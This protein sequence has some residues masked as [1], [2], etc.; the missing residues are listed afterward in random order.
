M[1]EDIS[2]GIMLN[3]L[4]RIAPVINRKTIFQR[5]IARE[6]VS[7]EG[8]MRKEYLKIPYL[9]CVFSYFEREDTILDKRII[10]VGD[11]VNQAMKVAVCMMNY[12]QKEESE[13][14]WYEQQ[15]DCKKWELKIINLTREIK[16]EEGLV[17]PWV[18][19]LE[20]RN[21][22]MVFYY[23]VNDGTTLKHKVDLIKG[24]KNLTDFIY[25]EK[26]DME[27]PWLLELMKDRESEIV[28]IEKVEEEY[29]RKILEQLLEGEPYYL[30]EKMNSDYLIKIWKKKSGNIFTEEDIAWALDR[31][32]RNKKRQENQFCLG[33]EDFS[34]EP[35]DIENPLVL[36]NH[37][38]G[39]KGVKQVALEYAALCKEKCRNPKLQDVSKHMIFVGN[40]GT[41]KTFCA[42]HMA[43]IAGTYGEA[44]GNYVAVTRK[45]LVGKYVGHTAPKVESL[46]RQTRGGI[47]FVDEAG[48]F[49]HDND[50]KGFAK[51]AIKEFVRFMDLYQDTTVI[52]SLYPMEVEEWLKQ[53]AGLSSRIGRVVEFEDYSMTEL[54]EITELM[55]KERGYYIAEDAKG[56]ALSYL[57]CLNK[58]KKENFGNAREA[59]KL[60]ESA[61]ISR[62]IRSFEAEA[63]D[64]SLLQKADF[65]ESLNRLK[66]AEIKKQRMGF[67]V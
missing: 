11:N 48:W 30:A 40:P 61:I 65:E 33:Y 8:S 13:E 29:Y 35:R 55:C 32:I 41:G 37:M 20:E 59:R 23:G 47:I 52:F 60:V 49:L 67:V 42:G 6:V 2:M 44:N 51:E 19:F 28:V 46:F 31:S 21:V 26:E 16:Y 36:I 56:V 27:K 45:D 24:S 66:M 7:L 39:L 18:D 64:E 58:E 3:K 57:E 62:S 15:N 14:E 4:G 25:I 63:E 22:N 12:W 10:L 43:K 1:G 9:S 53:D 34:L 54:L 17:N 5:N 50:N 38:I